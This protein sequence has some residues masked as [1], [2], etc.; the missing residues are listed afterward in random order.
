MSAGLMPREVGA[1]FSAFRREVWQSISFEECLFIF[2]PKIAGARGV[3]VNYFSASFHLDSRTHTEDKWVSY[4][5]GI[6]TAAWV[7]PLTSRSRRFNFR[8]ASC[9]ANQAG[10]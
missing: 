1:S 6:R 5:L 2:E 3:A 10:G 7:V 8:Q 4:G 9:S